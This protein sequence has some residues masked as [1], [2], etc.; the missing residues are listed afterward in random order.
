M[1]TT[2]LLQ[3]DPSSA[4]PMWPEEWDL[5]KDWRLVFR[6]L[7]G[8]NLHK[9]FVPPIQDEGSLGPPKSVR[10]LSIFLY[11]FC[12]W[13]RLRCVLCPL[14]ILGLSHTRSAPRN[15]VVLNAIE[16]T[17]WWK[18]LPVAGTDW[19]WSLAGFSPIELKRC[20]DLCRI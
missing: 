19:A 10:F 13:G 15:A 8:G 1:H 18:F 17:P 2:L 3:T 4:V 12:R 11:S 6:K 16:E 9:C 20:A 7:S 14:C 5:P